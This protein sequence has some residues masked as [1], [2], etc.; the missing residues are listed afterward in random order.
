VA[1]GSHED[2]ICGGM[3]ASQHKDYVFVLLFMKYVS[4]KAVS[5]KGYLLDAHQGGSEVEVLAARVEQYLKKM[6]F[7]S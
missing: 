3:D 4:D 6:G 1:L 7:H 5:Q 2:T